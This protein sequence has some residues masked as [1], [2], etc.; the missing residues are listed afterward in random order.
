MAPSQEMICSTHCYVHTWIA[1]L[2]ST[3]D[4]RGCLHTQIGVNELSL[5]ARRQ[6]MRQRKIWVRERGG[7]CGVMGR[8]LKSI[9]KELQNSPAKTLIVNPFHMINLHIKL[10]HNLPREANLLSDSCRI[11]ESVWPS[12]CW[13]LQFS[14]QNPRNK[15]RPKSCNLSIIPI[16]WSF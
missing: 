10:K 8:W 5:F 6:L 1:T 16:F 7:L 13:K 3:L 11:E 9:P 15:E 14:P 12:W 2:S 4:G